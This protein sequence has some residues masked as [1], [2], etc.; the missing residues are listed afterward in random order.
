[1]NANLLDAGAFGPIGSPDLDPQ[2]VAD[3]VAYLVS[4]VAFD[5]TGRVIHTA[6]A[7]IREYSTARTSRSDLVERFTAAVAAPKHT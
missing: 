2:H 4:D 6:G 7:A 5:I 1:M 3:V